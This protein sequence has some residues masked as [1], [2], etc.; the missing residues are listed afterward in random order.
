M[1]LISVCILMYMYMLYTAFFL[2]LDEGP[3]GA[4]LLI[5]QMHP[6]EEG[7]KSTLG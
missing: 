5:L 7:T 1:G 2:A 3:L 4:I 6:V